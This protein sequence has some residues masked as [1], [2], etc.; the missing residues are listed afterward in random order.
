MNSEILGKP[1]GSDFGFVFQRVDNIPRH[2]S[3]LYESACYFLI[4]AFGSWLY[5]NWEKLYPSGETKK[6]KKPLVLP[7][8]GLLFGTTIGLI[9]ICRFF[10]E[11]SKENQ[12]SFNLGIAL[13]MGQLL[14]IP[15]ILAGIFL[16]FRALKGQGSS[17]VSA[18]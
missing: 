8:T 5:W 11:F 12:E 10:I 4:F 17:S 3:M 16:V 14:S 9:F 6:K 7:P 15:F 18:P 2:P 1:T 13:N